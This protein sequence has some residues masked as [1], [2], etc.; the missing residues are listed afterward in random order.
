MQYRRLGRSGLKVSA[1]SLG[2]WLTYGNSVEDA[3]AR[4]CLRAAIEAGVNLLDTADVYADGQAEEVLGR[5]IRDHRR[6]DLVVATKVFFP[7]SEAPNDQGLSRKHVMESCE[8]SLRRLG[9]DYLDLYQCHRHDPD[10][11]LDELVRAMDDLIRQGKVLYW[12]VSEWTAEQLREVVGVARG[13]L[14]CPPISNQPLYNALE[15]DLEAEVLPTSVEL[16]IGQVV[17]SP[18]AQGV[19]TGKYLGGAVPPGS[20]L[21]NERLN[22]FMKRRL[23]ADNLRK[24]EAL[25]A[26]ARELG[27]PVATLALAWCLRQPNVAS[28]IVGASRPEQVR[29]N[30]AAADLAL[31]PAVL[32]RIEEALQTPPR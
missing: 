18:L 6:Q 4:D 9:L 24:V 2:S 25:A 16:G 12:G 13:L 30:V 32:A 3:T 31:S 20:R 28:V 7:M 11:P 8:A 17:F 29:E 21:A 14:A 26:I 1:V 22:A 15:R 19:L 23:S 10:T 5:L 27:V